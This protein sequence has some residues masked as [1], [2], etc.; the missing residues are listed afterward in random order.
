MNNWVIA[1][2]INVGKQSLEHP[3]ISSIGAFGLLVFEYGF[4]AVKAVLV[5]Y[6]LY[7][8]LIAL[9]WLTGTTAAKK[10]GIDT[11]AYGIDGVKRTVVLLALPVVARLIDII[12]NTNVIITGIVIAVLSRSI[13]RSVI[14]NTKR[15]GWDRWLPLW[16]I[17][18]VSDELE[19][20]DARAKQRLEE[21]TNREGEFK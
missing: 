7:V 10:Y 21:I 17:D 4:G 20:K 9:D 11:S 12:M 1:Q 13:A 18:W 19:H 2:T 15:A 8:L 16:A 14:A 6:L 3:L 5:A